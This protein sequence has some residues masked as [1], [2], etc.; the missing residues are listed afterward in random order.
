[1]KFYTVS[2]GNNSA[3]I[4]ALTTNYK[5]ERQVKILFLCESKKLSHFNLHSMKIILM[6]I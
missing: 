6:H 4:Y 5:I 3:D 2:L 1:M